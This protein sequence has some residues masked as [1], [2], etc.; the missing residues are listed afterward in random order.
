MISY[1]VFDIEFMEVVGFLFWLMIG[2]V[3]SHSMPNFLYTIASD[4][5]SFVLE[6]YEFIDGKAEWCPSFRRAMTDD[7]FV[8]YTETLIL[9]EDCSV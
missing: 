5:S 6:N 2:V 1:L 7:K 8:S 4:K 9:L 3:Q